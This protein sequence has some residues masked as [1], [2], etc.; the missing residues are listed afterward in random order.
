MI[1]TDDSGQL[2][3]LH[4]VIAAMI[5]GLIKEQES[6]YRRGTGKVELCYAPQGVAV[7]VCDPPVKTAYE[8]TRDKI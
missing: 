3:N 8:K 2:V 6:I 5:R 4:P 7:K 1:L